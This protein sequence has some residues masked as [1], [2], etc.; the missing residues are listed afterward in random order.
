MNTRLFV[1]HFL[2]LLALT[3]KAWCATY[4]P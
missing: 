1:W 4:A 3:S 2:L